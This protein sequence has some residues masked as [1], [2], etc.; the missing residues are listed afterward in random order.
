[1]GEV[2]SN[3]GVGGKEKNKHASKRLHQGTGNAGKAIVFGFLSRHGG[4]G[5]DRQR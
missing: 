3:L 1:M 5:E 2:R 4:G